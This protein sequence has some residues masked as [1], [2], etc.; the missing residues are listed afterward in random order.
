[1]MT[2]IQKTSNHAPKATGSLR[3]NLGLDYRTGQER[4]Q[5][6]SLW[7]KSLDLLENADGSE[8]TR[9]AHFL[10]HLASVYEERG[11]YAKTERLY[12][13]LTKLVERT[14]VDPELENLRVV[15]LRR[16]G[17]L[18]QAQGRPDEAENMLRRALICARA[19]FGEHH[20]ETAELRQHSKLPP[21]RPGPGAL[22]H[23]R[24][25]AYGADRQARR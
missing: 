21:H 25:I 17:S 7:L 23:L 8:L 12:Q 18:Y 9:L 4:Q 19:I 14:G 5:A 13:R 15:V 16:L 10:S 6:K 1:M 20:L 24:P 11:D 22:L 3:H 2:P